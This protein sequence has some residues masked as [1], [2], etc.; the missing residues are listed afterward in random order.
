MFL[1]GWHLREL[2]K[3]SPGGWHLHKSSLGRKTF[4]VFADSLCSGETPATLAHPLQSKHTTPN[5]AV[6]APRAALTGMA[7]QGLGGAQAPR[8]AV[9]SGPGADRLGAASK[10]ARG[11]TAQRLPSAPV[12]FNHDSGCGGLRLLAG[13]CMCLCLC[14]AEI[15][16]NF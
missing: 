9:V 8:R 15:A 13:V 6:R 11:V 5:P 12:T 14:V 3:G 4:S 10:P 16:F 2:S 1:E 7:Q